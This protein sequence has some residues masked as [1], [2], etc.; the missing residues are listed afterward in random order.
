MFIKN[1]NIL[2]D[3]INLAKGVPQG[4]VLSPLFFVLYVSD[5][6]KFFKN[7]NM[8]GIAEIL[9]SLYAEDIVMLVHVL[10][11]FKIILE[12]NEL[13]VKT[14][15]IKILVYQTSERINIVIDKD[16]TF[17][18]STI[19]IVKSYYCYLDTVFDSNL[20]GKSTNL[21]ASRRRRQASDTV[22]TV[23]FKLKFNSFFV[24]LLNRR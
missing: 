24:S 8:T 9:M 5:I 11:N 19:E 7:K 22:L 14:S 16:F 2:S 18:N 12:Q 4:D 6:I 21:E 20:C 23:I 3:P 17:K 13:L 1:D 15:K 10:L